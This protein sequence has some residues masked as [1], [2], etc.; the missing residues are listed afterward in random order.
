MGSQTV[1][2]ELTSCHVFNPPV[3]LMNHRIGYA[4]VSTEDPHL[5]LKRDALQ[6]AVSGVIYEEAKNGKSAARP[7]LDQSRKALR[8]DNA[9]LAC[10]HDLIAEEGSDPEGATAIWRKR[11]FVRSLVRW[12]VFSAPSK[13]RLGV[14]I[15]TPC[16]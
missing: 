12:S 14:M 4:R 16:A 2:A 1:S 5:D 7:E 6:Q 8:S 10:W 9:Q 11:L 3:A 13:A 15:V